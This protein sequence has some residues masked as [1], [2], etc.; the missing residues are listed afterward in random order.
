MM[1]E[2]DRDFKGNHDGGDFENSFK[3]EENGDDPYRSEYFL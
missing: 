2:Q 3:L 1:F